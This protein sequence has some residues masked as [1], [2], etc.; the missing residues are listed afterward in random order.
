VRALLGGY[1]VPARRGVALVHRGRVQ[2]GNARKRKAKL[3][4]ATFNA[5]LSSTA[6]AVGQAMVAVQETDDVE[7]ID[8]DSV[9]FD[10]TLAVDESEVEYHIRPAAIRSALTEFRPFAC[11]DYEFGYAACPSCHNDQAYY[12]HHADLAAGYSFRC[13]VCRAGMTVWAKPK[14]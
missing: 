5:V 13:R 11:Q 10:R 12:V 2:G 3:T 8:S 4:D 7:L 9:L 14:S 6:P 1:R